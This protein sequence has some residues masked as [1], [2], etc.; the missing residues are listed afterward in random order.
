MFCLENQLVGNG[1]TCFHRL[2]FRLV[3]HLLYNFLT[4][5][6]RPMFCWKNHKYKS[7]LLVFNDSCLVERTA[8]Y[9]C[10]T[11]CGADSRKHPNKVSRAES[12][13]SITITIRWYTCSFRVKVLLLLLTPWF[14]YSICLKRWM[15]FFVFIV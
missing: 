9:I 15:F 4:C 2:V 12:T 5:F 13:A 14:M 1:F 3:N 10:N 6:Q 8:K 7:V 11:S